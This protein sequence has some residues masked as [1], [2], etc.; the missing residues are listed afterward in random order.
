MKKSFLVAI[1]L[2]ASSVFADNNSSGDSISC[3]MTSGNSIQGSESKKSETRVSKESTVMRFESGIMAGTVQYK[4]GRII[5]M[6]I[7][8][9]KNFTFTQLNP[10]KIVEEKKGEVFL[11]DIM[12]DG[13]FMEIS[14]E[15]K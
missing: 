8:N 1:V 3:Q 2:F 6:M 9:T 12:N 14:C 5:Q 11:Q 7:E 13:Q 4:Y 15:I 10:M